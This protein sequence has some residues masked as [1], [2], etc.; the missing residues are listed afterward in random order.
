MDYKTQM[1]LVVVFEAILHVAVIVG[2]RYIKN[3]KQLRKSLLVI[4]PN[5]ILNSAIMFFTFS[6]TTNNFLPE[7]IGYDGENAEQRVERLEHYTRK[8]NN[9]LEYSNK[10]ILLLIGGLAVL[11]SIPL[12][13]IALALSKFEDAENH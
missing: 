5:I 11:N 10:Q 1:S 13:V 7:E 4:I 8:L 12:V 6:S 3:T 9:Y 2:A